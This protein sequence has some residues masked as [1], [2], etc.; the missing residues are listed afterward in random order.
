[1]ELRFNRCLISSF[2]FVSLLASILVASFAQSQAPSPTSTAPLRRVKV[3]E[4]AASALLIQKAGVQYPDA[5]RKAG[6]QGIVVLDVVTSNEGDVKEVT[7]SSG[8][9]VLAE[10][11]IDSVKQWKYKPYLVDGTP[12]EMESTVSIN[13]HLRTPPHSD[14]PPLGTFDDGN[15][16]NEFLDLYY[17]LSRDWVR[18]TDLMRKNYSAEG[19]STGIYVLLAA[20]HIPEHTAP[21]EADSSFVLSAIERSADSST[22]TCD[23]YLQRLASELQSKKEAQQ[24]GDRSDFS[25]AGHNF[26]RADFEFRHGPGHHAIICTQ[27]KDY[28]LQWNVAGFSKSAVQ[29]AVSTIDSVTAVPAVPAPRPPKY[30]PTYVQISSGV[31]QGLILKK[32]PPIY[33]EAARYGHIQGTVDLHAVINKT[34]DVVDLEVIDGPIELV[35][36]AV[37]AVRQWKYR[38]YILKGEPVEVDTTITVHYQLSGG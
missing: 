9:Y 10:A 28:L 6:T 20:V 32:V 35:V 14:P 16:V 23:L 5:A 27:V 15:Y 26:R 25:V 29:A 36:S 3:P 17:P 38:P 7:I 19:L 13:F 11:A 1:V 21:P 30:G 2:A 33:P 4:D 12:V 8:D 31:T 22:Q 24:K 34:G 37:N 18:E